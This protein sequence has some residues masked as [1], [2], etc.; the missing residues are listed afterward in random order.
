MTR[1]KELSKAELEVMKVLWKKHKA[2]IKEVHEELSSDRSW[3]YTTVMTFLERMYNKGY[4]DRE[5]VGM[6][7]VY[8]PKVSEKKTVGKM[9]NEFVD[10]VFDGALGPLV[11]YI[12]E[13]K[14]LKPKE[15][16][17]LKKLSRNLNKGG[18]RK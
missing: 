2:T 1:G 12:A 6:A 7:Y 8:E 5:K 16:E 10:R 18:E 11:N 15:M 4:V 9:V 14:E 13:S 17:A 3:G